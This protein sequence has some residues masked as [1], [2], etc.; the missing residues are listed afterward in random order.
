MTIADKAEKAGDLQKTADALEIYLGFR[1]KDIDTMSRW[2]FVLAKKAKTFQQKKRAA[3]VLERVAGDDPSRTK[4]LRESAEL[5]TELGRTVNPMFFRFAAPHWKTLGDLNPK[6]GTIVAKKA[7]AAAAAANF[8]EADTLYE[9]AIKLSPDVIDL[10]VDHANLLK[11]RMNMPD[12]AGTVINTMVSKNRDNAK[13]YVE[14]ARF[15][16]GMNADGYQEDLA[17]ARELK[18]DDLELRILTARLYMR[19]GTPA[20]A[21]DELKPILADNLKSFALYQELGRAQ[22][23]A[24]KADDAIATYR[25]GIAELP[26]AL[27]LNYALAEVY[28]T[29]GR[30][31]DA[32]PLIKTLRGNAALELDGTFLEAYSEYS[33][34]NYPQAI[35]TLESIVSV[36]S[37]L[38]VERR[39]SELDRKTNTLL[40][41]AE[42]LSGNPERALAAYNRAILTA[43][44]ATQLRLRVATVLLSLGRVD[45]AVRAYRDIPLAVPGARAGLIRARFVQNAAAPPEKRRWDDLER[46]VAEEERLATTPLERL[47]VRLTYLVARGQTTEARELVAKAHK[48]NPNEIFPALSLSELQLAEKN[49]ADSLKTLD[50]AQAK[51]GDKPEIRLSRVRYWTTVA[52]ADPAKKDE[53][54]K[55]LAAIGNDLSK[56]TAPAQSSIFESLSAA[57][58]RLGNREQSDLMLKDS[59]AQAPDDLR[60]R[61]KELSQAIESGKDDAVQEAIAQLKRI[62]GANGIFW[63]V[64]EANRLFIHAQ[65][66]RSANASANIKPTLEEARALIDE[67]FKLRPDQIEA[68]RVLGLIDDLDGKPEAALPRMLKVFE[69]GV[70]QPYMLR[71]LAYLLLERNRF[72]D[73]NRVMSAI[74][75]QGL[76][77][78]EEKKLTA[79]IAV[80]SGDTARAQK[81]LKEVIDPKSTD[82]LSYNWLAQMYLALKMP[83]EAEAAARRAVALSP[84]LAPAQLNLVL[85]IIASGDKAR[86]VAAAESA[87]KT[88]PATFKLEH[89]E[90][91]QAIGNLQLANKWYGEALAENPKDPRTLRETSQFYLTTNQ[92]EKAITG[93]RTL[94]ELEPAISPL[95]LHEVRRSLSAAL[96]NSRRPKALIEADSLIDANLKEQP[97][98]AADLR[99]KINVLAQLPSRRREAIKTFETLRSKQPLTPEEGFAY[100]Q[101]LDNEDQWP[102]ARTQV[103]AA[104]N[105]PNPPVRGA[106]WYINRLLRK[107]DLDESLAWITKFEKLEPKSID[108]PMLRARWMS[109]KKQNP[110]AVALMEAK[111]KDL[112]EYAPLF[113]RVLEEIHEPDAA[114]KMA[115][116]YMKTSK[117]PAA[118]LVLA[119]ALARNGQLPEA[120]D[121]MDS[122]WE[123]ADL[124]QMLIAISN[125]LDTPACRSDSEA[126]TRLL[127]GLTDALAKHPKSLA[128]MNLIAQVLVA[129][130]K[131][132]EAEEYYH[133]AMAVSPNDSSVYNNCAWMLTFVPG[134]TNDALNMIDKAIEMD[135]AESHFLDTRGLIYLTLGQGQK[136]AADFEQSIAGKPHDLATVHFHLALAQEANGARQKANESLRTAESLGFKPDTLHVLEQQSYHELLGKLGTQTKK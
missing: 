124:G 134:R 61:V 73:A 76:R 16:L 107:N 92:V 112:P 122:A 27:V 57:N 95:L 99:G 10:Y 45:E 68:T 85:S 3:E 47:T 89:A 126:H 72:V 50:E 101:I 43:S 130:K 71:R 80:R 41:Q 67:T 37:K 44:D 135:G 15:R 55:Q 58:R 54:A 18:P 25:Q 2:G 48:D 98:S 29:S 70:R 32:K 120:L 46:Y 62:E 133:R 82:A 74:E 129:E 5:Y 7:V 114:I 108:F 88:I 49:Y 52:A 60:L 97:D 53:A 6:D 39:P 121:L 110:A 119:E 12:R 35:K 93:L 66:A 21:I 40:G 31:A 22:T 8:K 125:V 131:F 14:R 132:G 28:I 116:E 4:E 1:K 100:A 63:R 34:K 90:V 20:K 69:Q 81:L 65:K 123:K 11:M 111:A 106:L 105:A 102:A 26:D 118:P 13:A 78:P 79:E 59:I 9:G 64:G 77:T 42:E 115:R 109:Q 86:A 113:A 23:F 83:P 87:E 51:F 36:L 94:M 104:L 17:K 30:F 33:Q 103:L 96:V 19:D 91:A 128:I 75:S 56:F 84:A 24:G 136:A 127:K 38:P 117:A